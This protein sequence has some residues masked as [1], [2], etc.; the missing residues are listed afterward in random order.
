MS[1]FAIPGTKCPWC[2][3]EIAYNGNYY[4][5]D[6][7][8]HNGTCKWSLPDD[9]DCTSTEK[10]AFNDAYTKLMHSTGRLP[11]SDAFML[12]KDGTPW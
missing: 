4:C 11:E 9:E 8:I 6:F 12:K 5:A 10:R 7:D 3:G 2:K 1:D